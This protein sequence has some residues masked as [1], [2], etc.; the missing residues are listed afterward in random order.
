MPTRVQ[1]PGT[2]KPRL[3]PLQGNHVSKAKAEPR[4]VPA[5]VTAAI[6]AAPL[7]AGVFQVDKPVVDFRGQILKCETLVFRPN[8]KLLLLTNTL[9][10]LA[11]VAKS[12][13]FAAPEIE[14][15]V[16]ILPN[17]NAPSA[18]PPQEFPLPRAKQGKKGGEGVV[19]GPGVDGIAGQ[20]GIDGVNA[21]PAPTLYLAAN[22]VFVQ[23]GAPIPDFISLTLHNLARYASEGQSGQDGQQGGKGGSGGN[24][25]WVASRLQCVTAA[26]SGGP[27]GAGGAGG[28]GG[29]G[30]DGGHGGDV[31]YIGSASAVDLLEYAKVRNEGTLGGFS[32]RAGVNG[33]PGPGGARGAHPGECT[34]GSTGPTG[35]A[36]NATPLDGKRGK[37]GERGAIMSTVMDVNVLF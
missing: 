20:D 13:K 16:G 30:G 2:S 1:K 7:T 14:A 17:K 25:V 35:K 31:H 10:W 12:I 28:N 32:G 15:Q 21:L 19:G 33:A 34:G 18:T 22:G 9:P 6:A 5:D 37:N 26:R 8:C 27:G 29:S 36:S 11:V 4:A 24:G 3:M 23:S